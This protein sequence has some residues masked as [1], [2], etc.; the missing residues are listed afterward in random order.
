MPPAAA[1]LL[2]ELYPPAVGGSAELLANVYGRFQRAPVTV[3]SDK[4]RHWGLLHPI[5]L[6]EHLRLAWRLRR[7]AARTK[8]VVHCGRALPEGLDAWLSR[9]AG[10]ARYVCWTHGEELTYI[11]ASR[12]LQQLLRRVHRRASMVIANSRNTAAMLLARGVPGDRIEVVYPGVDVRRFT[13]E[14]PAAAAVRGRLARPG[15]ALLLTVGRLQRR[16]GHDLALQAVAALH[17][18]GKSVRYIIAGDG[19]ERPRLERL[20]RELGIADHVTFT[21]KVPIDELPALF[22]AADVFVHP[23]RIENGDFEGFGIVFL[24]AAAAGLPVVGGDSGGVPEAVE[25]DVTGLLVSGT[26][27]DELVAVL[28]RL[29]DDDGLRRAMGA[30]GRRRVET[31]FSWEQA[32]ARM[33]AIHDRVASG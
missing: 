14:A 21:G 4:V 13:P 22:A 24:E 9:L 8:M 17:Q 31:T 32:A 33:E 6:G 18:S 1:L 5:G 15:E 26:D 30:A 28:R 27:A 16:K 23:N 19:E 29:L 25:R 10:G 3:W 12:E 20:A 7:A 2:T 11:A